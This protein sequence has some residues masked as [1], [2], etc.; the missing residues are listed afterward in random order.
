MKK[1]VFLL[2]QYG[3]PVIAEKC[4]GKTTAVQ[5]S[6]CKRCDFAF[7]L[8]YALSFPPGTF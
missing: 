6:H 4:P 3:I 1:N 7:L 5:Y 2:Q 8:K